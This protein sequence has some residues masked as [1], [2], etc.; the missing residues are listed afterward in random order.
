MGTSPSLGGAL[1][2]GFQV[3]MLE[4]QNFE[5]RFEVSPWVLPPIP[6]PPS[7][8]RGGSLIQ[9]LVFAPGVHIPVRCEDQI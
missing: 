4:F 6:N 2:E 9:P 7:P 5:R 1:A 8:W 3:R